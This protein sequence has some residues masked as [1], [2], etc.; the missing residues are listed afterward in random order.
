MF[1]Q[2]LLSMNCN[3]FHFYNNLFQRPGTAANLLW[4]S[5][6]QAHWLFFF[7]RHFVWVLSFPSGMAT[8]FLNPLCLIFCPLFSSSSPLTEW[9]TPCISTQEL[10]VHKLLRNSSHSWLLASSFQKLMFQ[11]ILSDPFEKQKEENQT[12]W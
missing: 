11:A 4:A 12:Q 1:P 2:N 10:T 3:W 7:L 9:N 6:Q 8:A 5:F